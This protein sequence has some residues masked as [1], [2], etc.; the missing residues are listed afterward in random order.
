MVQDEANRI[1]IERT[2]ALVP[3][4]TKSM[5]DAGCG[6]GVFVNYL[7]ETRNGISIT[8]VDRS[9]AALAYVKTNKQEASVDA[10]PFADQ[11]FDCVSCLEVIEHLPETI[12]EK[13]LDE[14]ARVSKGC[15]I[16][17]VPYKEKLEES[18]TRCPACR[19]IFNYELH[20]RS[21]NDDAMKKLMLSRGYSCTEMITT[22][23]GKTLYG[24]RLFRKIFYPEQLLKWNSPICPICGFK[25]NA[26]WQPTAEQGVGY[27]Q[28]GA[29]KKRK[30]I[31]YFTAIP[32]L[33][34]PKVRK[35]Y[36]VIVKYEKINR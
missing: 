33:I 13:S 17:S 34:W 19:S 29:L 20:L 31:S 7:A 23:T 26:A 30:L 8:G 22:G 36:W 10:L 12:Y 6:N 5:L 21:F 32:K 27:V 14:L 28:T 2:A 4:D 16:I 1:R 9:S 15:I 25:G 18:Y 24:H 3:E 11:S 35:D